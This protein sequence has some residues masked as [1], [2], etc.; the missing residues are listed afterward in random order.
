MPGFRRLLTLLALTFAFAWLGSGAAQAAGNPDR[1]PAPT[2]PDVTISCAQGFD[3]VAHVV[4]N[5]EYV[6]SFTRSDGTQIF[7]VDGYF[8]ATVSGNGKSFF[9]NASGPGTFVFRPNGSVTFVQYGRT[10][11]IA[12]DLTDAKI[13]VGLTTGRRRRQHP[14]SLR[15]Q[16]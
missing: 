3:A 14:D 11:F 15:N 5:N 13:L 12:P 8:A 16:Y 1:Q 6:L 10:F 2:P 7:K 4:A 9:F